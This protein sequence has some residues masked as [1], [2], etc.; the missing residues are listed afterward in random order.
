MISISQTNSPCVQFVPS[1]TLLFHINKISKIVLCILLVIMTNIQPVVR[2]TLTSLW[3]MCENL[4]SVS[5]ILCLTSQNVGERQRYQWERVGAIGDN[6]LLIGSSVS[7]EECLIDAVVTRWF[8][9]NICFVFLLV[10][11]LILGQLCLWVN[12]TVHTSDD[13]NGSWRLPPPPKTQNC[14]KI[15]KYNCFVH[16]W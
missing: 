10:T 11:E 9:L 2:H 15:K 7:S 4:F 3:E 16:W 8:C 12:G 1:K 13:M 5:T 14:Q 6:T